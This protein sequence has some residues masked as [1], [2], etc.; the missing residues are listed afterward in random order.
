MKEIQ[1]T[2]GK[3][4]LIDDDDYEKINEFKWC[5]SFDPKSGKYYAEHSIVLELK[6][7]L[8][9]K[10]I[11]M[12]R[13]ILGTTNSKIH[14]DHIDGNTLNNV[15]TNLREA[16][17]TQN[18]AN[19]I[20]MS[21][22]NSSGFRGVYFKKNNN[23]NV[24]GRKYTAERRNWVAQININGKRTT[25]GYFSTPKKA[26]RAFDKAQRRELFY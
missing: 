19:R 2:Q 20:I 18:G 22:A 12:H 6:P 24:S 14:V 9:T 5:A 15:K 21:K 25:L 8:K 17:P 23:V 16:T 11:K 4:A 26:A 1:L 13:I 3:V 10:S 7:K